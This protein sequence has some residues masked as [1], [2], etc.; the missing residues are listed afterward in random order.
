MTLPRQI[1]F[2]ASAIMMMVMV[3]QGCGSKDQTCEFDG[4]AK[5]DLSA[6]LVREKDSV[7]FQLQKLVC[8]KNRTYT[9]DDIRKTFQATDW[10]Y[11]SKAATPLMHLL[12]LHICYIIFVLSTAL[13]TKFR[14]ASK[15]E[16]LFVSERL[17]DVAMQLL[18]DGDHF[19]VKRMHCSQAKEFSYDQLPELHVSPSGTCLDTLQRYKLTLEEIWVSVCR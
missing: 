3:L 4:K 15:D 12:P 19:K 5:K 1:A 14:V 13:S 9:L 11:A 17:P 6:T 2:L 16:C 8:S 10:A 7:V 18:K